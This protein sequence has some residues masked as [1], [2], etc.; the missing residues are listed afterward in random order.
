MRFSKALRP[1]TIAIVTLSAGVRSL[2]AQ[3]S[4]LEL[5]NTQAATSQI[6]LSLR[7]TSRGSSIWRGV[8]WGAAVGAVAAGS[9][10]ALNE[11]CRKDGGVFEDAVFG[12][13]L[14]AA[15]GAS[16]GAVAYDKSTLANHRGVGSGV[17]LRVRVRVIT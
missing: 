10:C 2:E 1:A 17:A 14:G 5:G 4:R 9:V 3:S 8:I 16:I 12:A 6:P 15:V 13:A 7:S 11:T